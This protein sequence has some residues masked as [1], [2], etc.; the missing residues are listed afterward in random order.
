MPLSIHKYLNIKN[1]YCVCYYGA[2]K[3]YIIQLKALRP[4][5]ESQYQGIKVYISVADNNLYLLKGE[6]K[7][8]PKSEIN[9]KKQEIS[10]M[11]E[12]FS[13]LEFHSVEKLLEESEIQ[14]NLSIKQKT[15]DKPEIGA[16]LTK[17]NFPNRSLSFKQIEAAEKFL[18]EKG[19]RKIKINPSFDDF[20]L[21]DIIIG[22]EN[23]ITYEYAL[24]G[25]KTYLVPTGNGEKLFLKMFPKNELIHLT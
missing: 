17:G 2:N 9:L 12:I 5:I 16:I 24:K 10:Y 19:I 3:E 20:E 14:I 15:I 8:I 1:N 25:I 23:E 7:I 13:S 22:V 18:Y 11:R 4:L 21:I 6:D